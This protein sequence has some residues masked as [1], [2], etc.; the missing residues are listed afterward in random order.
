MTHN[1][2]TQK[3]TKKMSNTD[4]VI[5]PAVNAYVRE[6][7]AVPASVLEMIKS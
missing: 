6:G 4:P 7:Q 5:K 2:V 1:R 3:K